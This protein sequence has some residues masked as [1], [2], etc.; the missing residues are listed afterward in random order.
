MMQMTDE[1]IIQRI[2]NGEKSLYELI[3]RKYNPYLYKIGRVYNYNHEDTEDLMQDTYVDA[4]KNLST[5]QERASF[6]TWLVRIMMNNCYRKNKK[7][8]YKN[9]VGEDAASD[10]KLHALN[11]TND[12]HTMVE[13]R[14]IGYAIERALL[15]I[16]EEYRMVFTLREMNGLNTSE[17]AELLSISESNVKTRLTRSK[18]MLRDVIAKSYDANQLYA[19]NLVYCDAMVD[20]VFN[21]IKNL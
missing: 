8:S 6:K 19:F 11:T 18:T 10:T 20:R 16:P 21:A 2:L 9:D 3:V 1:E 12:T 7:L 14:E 13:N 17:T 15:Q 4:Y 5:F